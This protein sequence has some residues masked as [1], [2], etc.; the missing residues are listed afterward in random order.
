MTL[1]RLIA[2][3]RNDVLVSSNAD[4]MEKLKENCSICLD[5]FDLK[6]EIADHGKFLHPNHL[7]C[8][9][10]SL[11]E[12]AKCVNCRQPLDFAEL[13]GK[14]I[15]DITAQSTDI[16]ELLNKLKYLLPKASWDEIH[17]ACLIRQN[18]NA[19]ALLRRALPHI[20]KIQELDA[21]SRALICIEDTAR[22][23]PSLTVEEATDRLK[24]NTIIESLRDNLVME[25]GKM[26]SFL[27]SAPLTWKEKMIQNSKT[28]GKI[29]LGLGVAC[30]SAAATAALP[31]KFGHLGIGLAYVMPMITGLS[32]ACA[33]DHARVLTGSRAAT[34]AAV[35]TVTGAAL[36]A[37]GVTASM[38]GGD[39]KAVFITELVTGMAC[40]VGGGVTTIL[41]SGLKTALVAG[42]AMLV[43]TGFGI[44]TSLAMM[45]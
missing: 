45:K 15:T 19:L 17:N 2:I 26:V 44:N 16:H 34:V 32:V 33:S 36:A 24:N 8:I 1:D 9:L 37:A 41:N 4:L 11:H 30:T 38:M 18:E 6:K 40:T 5:T 29:A 12:S 22:A 28:V 27:N 7:E 20:V 31:L 25:F 3:N 21:R 35:S 13:R 43:T 42:V 14:F 39:I 10:Q 23:R